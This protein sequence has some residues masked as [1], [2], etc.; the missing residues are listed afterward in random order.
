[1][2]D[3]IAGIDALLRDRLLIMVNDRSAIEIL[4]HV[5]AHTGGLVL[6]GADA[7]VRCKEIRNA[8][9]QTVVAMDHGSHTQTIA[10]AEAPFGLRTRLGW[11]D[12]DLTDLNE[13]LDGQRDN[14]A[15]FAVTPTCFIPADTTGDALV[16]R[17]AIGQANQ[18]L[19]EDTV[20]LLPCS[21]RWLRGVPLRQLVEQIRA[22]RHPVALILQADGDPLER[23]GASDG[24]RQLCRSCPRL[25][26]WRTDLAAFDA[27]AH[28]AMGA[29]IGASAVLRHGVAP[30]PDS[31]GGGHKPYP[32]VLIRRLLRYVRVTTLLD[33]FA[34]L[35]PWI[36][37]CAVCNG[38]SLARFTDRDHDVLAALQHTVRELYV[39]HDGLA[40]TLPGY[41]RVDWWRQKLAD[42]AEHHRRLA[43]ETE[44]E[45]LYP[46]VLQY[47]R[48]SSPL[49]L[50]PAQHHRSHDQRRPS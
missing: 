22:C 14:K 26:L 38:A 21:W 40:A 7:P 20:V 27:M 4:P 33:W 23:A 29:A 48:R 36:C 44:L 16:L 39:L 9:G 50:P 24:L 46:R 34:R 19:R 17:S 49:P 42:S 25:M 1:M 10:T 5:R 12:L 11:R 43:A 3:G 6:T 45:V 30:R 13:V 8:R 2:G 35:D 37:D 15:S 32:V 41:E 18:L 31:G 28:G 47:W